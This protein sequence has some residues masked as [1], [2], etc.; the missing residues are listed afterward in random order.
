M[1]TEWETYIYKIDYVEHHR[2][3]LPA[4]RVKLNPTETKY[5]RGYRQIEG[6]DITCREVDLGSM[7]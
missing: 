6:E 5:L 4:D 1:Q 2:E 3:A 7:T